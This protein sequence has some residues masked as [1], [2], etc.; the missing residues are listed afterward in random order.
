[1]NV[2]LLFIGL[3]S[4]VDDNGVGL[5]DYRQIAA[6]LFALE[7]DQ[8]GIREYVRDS[9]ATLSRGLQVTRYKIA[10][11][12]YL[13]ITAWDAHQKVDR[14][15]KARYPRPSAGFDPSTSGNSHQPGLVLDQ[16]AT[17]SRQPRDSPASVVGSRGKG[18]ERRKSKTC[19]PRSA[20]DHG[21]PQP[22]DHRT[23]HDP[24][25][26]FDLELTPSVEAVVP[27]TRKADR[28]ANEAFARFWKVYPRKKS[29]Q[30]ARE[31]WDKAIK[32]A[33]VDV[34]VEAARRYAD[35]KR[36][37]Q[38]TLYPATWLNRGCWEDEV[39]PAYNNHHVGY[40]E[41]ATQADYFEGFAP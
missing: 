35:N 10:D 36:D 30:H 21:Q 1:M 17:A 19:A 15:N 38:Y 31:A 33:T 2:R 23:T 39:D 12:A 9:L 24:E 29:K 20:S 16:V 27:I 13:F 11:K 8:D 34:L 41:T 5:D 26:L 37:P 6:D 7:E 4:Y 40:Q 32:R 28:Q 3:W 22:Q 25:A 14:P 18:E